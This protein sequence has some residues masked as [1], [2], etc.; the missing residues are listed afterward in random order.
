MREIVVMLG[1][2][3]PLFLVCVLHRNRQGNED[4]RTFEPTNESADCWS[5]AH[6]YNFNIRVK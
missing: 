5:A 6:R 1:W 3:T 4:T 2:L